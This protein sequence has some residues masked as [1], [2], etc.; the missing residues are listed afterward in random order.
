MDYTYTSGNPPAGLGAGGEMDATLTSYLGPPNQGVPLDIDASGRNV[1]ETQDLPAAWLGKNIGMERLIKGVTFDRADFYITEILPAQEMDGLEVA[2]VTF[3]YNK[4]Y[5]DV[6]PYEGTPNYITLTEGGGKDRLL[7]RGM[8]ISIDHQFFKTPEGQEQY[9]NQLETLINS[10]QLT[11][12][13]MVI[14]ALIRAKNYYRL[15]SLKFMLP[16]TTWESALTESKRRWALLN[17]GMHEFRSFHFDL[18]EDMQANNASPNAWILPPKSK[19]L[20]ALAHST[21][22]EYYSGGELAVYNREKGNKAIEGFDNF[23]FFE[24]LI[25]HDTIYGQSK[26]P[27]QREREYGSFFWLTN[28]HGD[29]HLDTYTNNQRYACRI[30]DADKDGEETLVKGNMLWDASMRFDTHGNLHKINHQ[31]VITKY[32]D[33]ARRLGDVA[34]PKHD[35]DMFIGY[36]RSTGTPANVFTEL[37]SMKEPPRKNG[38]FVMDY[39]G[40]MRQEDVH[41]DDVRSFAKTAERKIYAVLTPDERTALLRTQSFLDGLYNEVSI[42]SADALCYWRAVAFSA[43]PGYENE[44]NDGVMRGHHKGC[45]K[46]PLL[47]VKKDYLGVKKGDTKMALIFDEDGIITGEIE[48]NAIDDKTKG[49]KSIK[50]G[51]PY[52]FGHPTGLATL[53]EM[54]AQKDYRGY[55]KSLLEEASLQYGLLVKVFSVW[56]SLFPG[57]ALG[58]YQYCPDYFQTLQENY[59]SLTVFGLNLYMTNRFPVYVNDDSEL[60]GESKSKEKDKSTDKSGPD[61]STAT[62]S[63][64]LPGASGILQSAKKQKGPLMRPL[65]RPAGATLVS[66]PAGARLDAPEDHYL[67][68][69]CVHPDVFVRF[70]ASKKK[71]SVVFPMRVSPNYS[72][73]DDVNEF[74][75]AAGPR[76][77]QHVN[78]L[79][80]SLFL[81]GHCS[82]D[83]SIGKK[84]KLVANPLQGYK[85]DAINKRLENNAIFN[86][87]TLSVHGE[88]HAEVTARFNTYAT[89]SDSIR[90]L[91]CQSWA[92]TRITRQSLETWWKHDCI[93]L[94][95][96]ELWRVRQRYNMGTGFMVQTGGALG[97]TY[98]SRHDFT[99]SLDSVPKRWIGNY[100][101]H[102]SAVVKDDT[103]MAIVEDMVSLGYLH[104][105]DVTFIKSPEDFN[106]RFGFSGQ[107]D[108]TKGSILVKM[109]PYRYKGRRD[110]PKSPQDIGGRWNAAVRRLRDETTL[111]PPTSATHGQSV[112]YYA[113]LLKLDELNKDQFRQ[114]RTYVGAQKVIN[115]VGW[116]GHHRIYDPV[117]GSFDMVVLDDGPFGH[118]IYKGVIRDRDGSKGR[119]IKEVEY[120]NVYAPT[121]E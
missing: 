87:E 104:G 95:S 81:R 119:A 110:F 73:I 68:L 113:Q 54:Y 58:D 63:K 52:G 74:N 98:H 70:K 49:L 47:N 116:R 12:Y 75:Y 25:F 114:A 94:V 39:W 100:T 20:M 37:Y 105:E 14:Q 86:L 5:F 17:K 76:E 46:P 41:D 43:R 83:A 31:N 29:S 84:R 67:S 26:N 93:P 34:T 42:D 107:T 1:R 13:Y 53:A 38:Y 77:V 91:L 7:Q 33:L 28:Y 117:K 92:T 82:E 85:E 9:R 78:A 106:A 64:S 51:L 4:S 10:A 108:P 8:G 115:T 21:E 96:F 72:M 121:A 15:N 2:W 35:I 40:E 71:D 36:S 88:Y 79:G 16:T 44:A 19:I 6:L 48:E 99:W 102:T 24:T 27:L 101:F 22:R 111:N 118:S 3:Q 120:P 62:V 97:R 45:I 23:K 69:L 109:T 61:A 30:M 32:D 59:D 66:S 103:K 89:D 80:N 18:K 90:R 60:S 50:L 65:G 11:L 55:D 56:K 57:H 112:Y